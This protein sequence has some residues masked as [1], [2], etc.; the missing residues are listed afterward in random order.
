MASH[1][2]HGRPWSARLREFRIVARAA[3]DRHRP[4]LVHIIP[5]RRCNLACAYC[6]E[7]D[8]HSPPVALEVM[9]GRID[10][11]AA[12]GTAVV[13]VSGGEPLLHPNLDM[14]IRRIHDRGMIGT[15]ITNGY[16][17]GP[18][19]IQALNAARLDRLQISIDNVKPDAVSKKSLTVLDR[20][21]AHLAEHARFDVNINCVLGSGVAQPEDALTIAKR[22]GEFGFTSTMGIIHDGSGH[23]KP[24]SNPSRAIYDQFQ[25]LNRSSLG[26]FNR[27]FQLRL[28][29]GRPNDWR[30]RAGARYF[31]V[32]ED[33]LVHYC[34]QQRGRPGIPLDQFTLAHRQSAYAE[35]KSC[36]PFC[37]IACAHQAS[38][39][40]G[41]RGRQHPPAP[42][43]AAEV[44]ARRHLPLVPRP[45][46]EP[47]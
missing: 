24:L 44:H 13:T 45:T 14:I 8:D 2:R 28:A 20:K 26:R 35:Q 7:Y 18:E 39:L 33:G 27:S 12:L 5:M 31:Y 37:T 46:V 42:A 30:C 19:R 38:S 1:R 11:L 3:L 4:L 25:D 9:F 15:L 41:W 22:A 17:L 34:S 29:E 47:T 32:C 10:R 23:L 36:A 43:A 40:D 16:R 21:L 6:N